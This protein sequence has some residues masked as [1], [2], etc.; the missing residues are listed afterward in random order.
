MRATPPASIAPRRLQTVVLDL[1]KTFFWP[2]LEFLNLNQL[3]TSV[4]KNCPKRRRFDPRFSTRPNS[5]P[6]R[7]GKKKDVCVSQ[8]TL[9][10]NCQ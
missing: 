9:G 5:G 4:S 6:Y 10:V 7:R 3:F 8:Q 2:W 1:A